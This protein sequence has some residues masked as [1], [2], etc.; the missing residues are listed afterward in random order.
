MPDIG[1][2]CSVGS[3]AGQANFVNV[4]KRLSRLVANP[5]KEI[6]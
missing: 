2:F 4:Q 3:I 5:G 1:V 6:L